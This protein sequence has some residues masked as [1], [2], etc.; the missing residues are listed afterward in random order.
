MLENQE[1]KLHGR[2]WAAVEQT[3]SNNLSIIGPI[4]LFIK[5]R[6]V[7]FIL[8]PRPIGRRKLKSTRYILYCTLFI[9]PILASSTKDGH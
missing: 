5:L 9:S 4:I 1:K 6:S 7:N 8:C 3:F 2:Q